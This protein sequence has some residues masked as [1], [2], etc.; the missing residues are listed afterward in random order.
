MHGLKICFLLFLGVFATVHVY[1][2]YTLL[3]LL[4]KEVK[5]SSIGGLVQY[6]LDTANQ[7]VQ[8]AINKKMMAIR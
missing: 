2:I 7:A 1:L 4:R 6:L 3:N 8:S 5:D